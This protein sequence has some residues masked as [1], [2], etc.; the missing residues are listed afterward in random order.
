ML[1]EDIIK[2]P[3]REAMAILDKGRPHNC[4]WRDV[5]S[6][7]EENYSQEQIVQVN[8]FLW[9]ALNA[10]DLESEEADEIRDC[11]DYWRYAMED[12]QDFDKVL[13]QYLGE[14]EKNVID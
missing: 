10:I 1:F 12:P 11:C 7:V 6:F 2:L 13:H 3:W 8:I 14:D 4:T 9:K 5:S